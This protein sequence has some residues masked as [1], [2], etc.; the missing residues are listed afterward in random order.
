VMDSE[1]TKL[2]GCTFTM[3]LP[4]ESPDSVENGWISYF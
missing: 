1:R 3:L 2:A 4:L